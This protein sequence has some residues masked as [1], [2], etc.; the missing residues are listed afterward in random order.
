MEAEAFSFPAPCL[1]VITALEML[2]SP[3]FILC[4]S[5]SS[6]QTDPH[7]LGS[8]V[9]NRACFNVPGYMPRRLRE[10]VPCPLDEFSARVLGAGLSF[11][12]K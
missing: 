9:Y 4:L 6:K 12:H 3:V 11:P 2:R 1:R 7:I 5:H 8:L 10:A